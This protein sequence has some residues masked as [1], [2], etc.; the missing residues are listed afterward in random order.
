[1]YNL[2]DLSRTS[3][4]LVLYLEEKCLFLL[5]SFISVLFSDEDKS[6]QKEYSQQV[7]SALKSSVFLVSIHH[8][9][10]PTVKTM[11][12]HLDDH[13]GTSQID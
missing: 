1:M 11:L 4:V 12:M 5:I 6:L 13:V 3:D 9:Y 7:P 10:G 2:K 8:I